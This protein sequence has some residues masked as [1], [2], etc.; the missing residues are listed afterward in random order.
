MI[1]GTPVKTRD[2]EWNIDLN[3]SRNKNKVIKLTE[4]LDAYE[5]GSPSLSEGETWAIVGRPYGEIYTAGFMRNDDGKIIV[6]ELGI[7]K[8]DTSADPMASVYLGNFNYDWRSGMTHYLRYKNWNLSFLIDLNYGGVRQSS[9][10]AMM[11]ETGTSKASLEGRESGIVFDGVQEIVATDG[12]KTYVPNTINIPA[13]TY[14][15][16]I[17]G[18][19][20]GGSG[21]PF[22]HEAT[23]ARL[24][25]F[26]LGYTIPVRS[27]IVKSLRVSAVGRN[28]FYIYN[29][30][31]WFDPDVTYDIDKNGQGAES[32]FLPGTRTLGFN[33]KLTL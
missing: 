14:A 21:E 6:D 8:I 33:I 27:S 20:S 30:C 1:S 23:N 19:I 4:K 15:S 18:R 26:S 2:F 10:E 28:L 13:E 31:K 7:P 9:T 5:I 16:L 32:A 24:R 12:S 17:G 3:F 25:E 11:L 29:G 22:N